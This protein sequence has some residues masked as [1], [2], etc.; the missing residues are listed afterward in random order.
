[1]NLRHP[2]ISSTIGIV[3]PSP[4]QKLQII[5]QH[6]GRGSLS[7][8]I[9]TSPEWWTPTAKAKA[10]VGIVL[11]MRFAHRFGLLDGHLTGDNVL[12]DDDGLIPICDFF[13]EL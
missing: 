2:C 7:E 13:Q 8:V 9:S 1:M 5:R 3:F 12:C 11:G 4:L 6:L 10:I